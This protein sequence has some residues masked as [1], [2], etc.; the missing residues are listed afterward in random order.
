MAASMRCNSLTVPAQIDTLPP[1]CG[2]MCVANMSGRGQQFAFAPKGDIVSERASGSSAFSCEPI[3]RRQLVSGL[4]AGAVGLSLSSFGSLSR[5]CAEMNSLDDL[6]STAV[7]RLHAFDYRGVRLLESPLQRQMLQT[8]DMYF[9]M[10]NDDML[11]GYRR[12][13]GMPAPGH[14]MAGWSA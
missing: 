2:E 8:R 12:M 11:K 14:D 4:A 6:P 13:A 1:R 9:N 10:N 5:A 3:S 7:K